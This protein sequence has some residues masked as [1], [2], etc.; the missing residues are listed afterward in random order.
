MVSIKEVSY[1]NYGKCMQLSNGEIELCVTLE[2]G[3]R[4]IRFAR[5]GGE[6]MMFEDL[7][8]TQVQRGSAFDSYYGEGSA[9]YIYGG[10]RLW[11]SPEALPRSYYPDNTPPKAQVIENGVILTCPEQIRNNLQMTTMITMCPDSPHVT[12]THHIKNTG[13]FPAEF[14][15]WGLSVMAAGGK[16]AVP[17]PQRDTGLLSNRA[18]ALWPYSR[19]TDPRVCWGDRYITLRQDPGIADAF[20][21]GINNE[22]GF[23]MYF[24]HNALFVKQFDYLPGVTYPD[25]GMN[26]ETY[27]NAYFLEVESIGPLTMVG[28]GETIT[29]TERWSL[30]GDVAMPE[31]DADALGKVADTYVYGK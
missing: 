28:S 25:G 20:K 2:L 7:E 11:A 6:N 29:H 19:M 18:I 21:L 23:A 31:S 10:H 3:P 4:I 13:A 22:D 16:V 9:W 27:A 5:T 30:Y 15:A 1:Q 8:R 12:V 14:A 26:F 17:V 24:N